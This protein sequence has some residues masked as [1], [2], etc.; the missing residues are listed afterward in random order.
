MRAPT[1]LPEVE[2][3]AHNAWRSGF[4]H[5]FPVALVIGIAIGVILVKAVHA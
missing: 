3:V 4:W 2:S 1:P 5:A